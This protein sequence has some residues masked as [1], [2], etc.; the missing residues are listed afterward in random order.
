MRLQFQENVQGMI[1]K[2][3]LWILIGF[4]ADPDPNPAFISVRFRN[5][6]QGAKPIRIHADLDP[7]PDHGQTLP[8]QKV[9]FF[10]L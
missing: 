7:D 6:I 3:M 1:S 8:S 4:V 5:R 9:E 2:Q 10:Y